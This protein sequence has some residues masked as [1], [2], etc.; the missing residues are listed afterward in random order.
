[1]GFQTTKEIIKKQKLK[2]VRNNNF[3]RVSFYDG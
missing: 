1:M 2:G 3:H